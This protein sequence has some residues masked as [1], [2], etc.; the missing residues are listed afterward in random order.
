MGFLFPLNFTHERNPLKL[1]PVP[2]L[3][4][5]LMIRGII[6]ATINV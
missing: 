2:F 6:A 3:N 4:T 5:Q 1:T